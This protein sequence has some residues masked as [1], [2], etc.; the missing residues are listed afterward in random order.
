MITQKDRCL[1][2]SKQ[3]HRL[4][5]PNIL[6]ASLVCYDTHSKLEGCKTKA[7]VQALPF[8]EHPVLECLLCILMHLKSNLCWCVA[9]SKALACASQESM[10][11]LA[12]L[13][14]KVPKFNGENDTKT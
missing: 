11:I 13:A 10:S 1:L 14:K 12:N 5:A 9:C 3:P 4:Q 7:V 2:H 8:Q 6:K